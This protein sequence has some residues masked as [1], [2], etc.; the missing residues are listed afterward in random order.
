MQL[1]QPLL[2]EADKFTNSSMKI[3][4]NAYESIKAML[5]KMQYEHDNLRN[6]Y[7]YHSILTLICVRLR[8]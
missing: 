4:Q 6:Y 3:R 2:T 8:L 5:E 1:I 7:I